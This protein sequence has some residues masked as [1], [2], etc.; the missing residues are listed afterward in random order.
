MWS[1]QLPWVNWESCLRQLEVPWSVKHHQLHQALASFWRNHALHHR[2]L[3]LLVELQKPIGGLLRQHRFISTRRLL[4]KVWH[5]FWLPFLRQCLINTW[6]GVLIYVL[7]YF[8]YLRYLR[9]GII[10]RPPSVK[11][12]NLVNIQFIYM[13]ILGSIAEGMLSLQIWK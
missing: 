3:L 10:T 4:P 9:W 2:H 6:L 7:R 8:C 12:H 11:W 13:N 5:F 1:R